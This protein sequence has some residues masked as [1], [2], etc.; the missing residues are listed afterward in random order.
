M[1]YSFRLSTVKANKL[2]YA[3]VGAFALF[4]ISIQIFMPYLIVYYEKSLGMSNYVLVLAPAII[5][6]AVFTA[7]YGKFYD[8][9][10]FQKSIIPAIGIL[11]AGYVILYFSVSM[12]PVFVG[13]LLMMCGY[14]AGMAVFGAVIR[15]RIPEQMEGRFQGLRI[16]GQV[17][18]PG[19]I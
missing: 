2:L 8:Q 19:V 13:S 15:E 6:A 7:V 9:L 12:V 5:L 17:L 3:I 18:I 14:L 16:I 10:G 4:G 11:V 1:I